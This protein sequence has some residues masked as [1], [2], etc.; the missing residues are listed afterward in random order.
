M[1]AQQHYPKGLF[2]LFFILLFFMVGFALIQSLLVLYCTSIFHFDDA[3]AYSLYAAY[4]ALVFGV[5]L[6]GG[7]IGGNV[8]D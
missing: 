7:Y 1:M 3:D 5:P 6:L 2:S 8:L 4:G